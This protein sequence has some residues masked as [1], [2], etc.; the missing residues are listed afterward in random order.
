MASVGAVLVTGATVSAG[1]WLESSDGLSR[2]MVEDTGLNLYWTSP[3]Y[4]TKGMQIWSSGTPKPAEGMYL[5]M[6]TDG[7]LC[8]Y[9]GTPQASGPLLWQS[10]VTLGT[11]SYETRMQE[12]GNLCVY[13]SGLV[14]PI[15]CM[16][17]SKT[18]R[19]R[20]MVQGTFGN[21]SDL[22]LTSHSDDSQV[23]VNWM[24]DQSKTVTQVF[25]YTELIANDQPW[26]FTLMD[27]NTLQLV[28]SY[29]DQ[30]DSVRMANFIS[31][32]SVLIK[33]DAGEDSPAPSDWVGIRAANA[34]DNHFN[35]V[36]YPPF[37]TGT[38]VIIYPW[39]RPAESNMLWK[40]I[41]VT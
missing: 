27:V 30:G 24:A 20:V 36:G 6:Q 7:N 23:T 22:Y 26:G 4:P 19:G 5:I 1:D 11:G 29:N 37:G 10:G 13:L 25:E 14:N 38:K 3:K 9:A 40:F 33:V 32:L 28:S 12:D 41:P 18:P 34:G 2:F 16:K 8:L 17:C 21:A 35:V 31:T 39:V 15:W